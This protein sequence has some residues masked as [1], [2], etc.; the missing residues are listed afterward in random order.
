MFTYKS[1]SLLT[2]S[3]VKVYLSVVNILKYKRNQ[4]KMS[5]MKLI[6]YNGRGRAET[7]RLVFALAGKEFDDH[8]IKAGTKHFE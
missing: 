6:Y 4:S 7:I 1:S 2:F 5:G 8:R 3:S